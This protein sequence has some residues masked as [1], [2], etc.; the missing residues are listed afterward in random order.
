MIVYY[1]INHGKENLGL[2]REREQG[3]QG[4]AE[5][6]RRRV[7]KLLGLCCVQR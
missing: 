1:N 7:Q 6:K 5:N 3:A 2:A 4:E